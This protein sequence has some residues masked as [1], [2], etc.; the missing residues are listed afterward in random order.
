MAA[1]T[2]VPPRSL[3]PDPET[4]RAWSWGGVVLILAGCLAVEVV[5]GLVTSATAESWYPTLQKPT[6]TPP[7]WVFGPVWTLLFGM[8]AVA[9]SIVWL[10]RDNE[11]V[12]CPLTGFSVQLAANLLWSVLFFGLH[13]PFLA[14]LDL[15][16]LWVAVGVTLAQFFNVSRLAAALMVPYFVW[17]TFAALL[18]GAIVAMAA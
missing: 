10:A 14:F 2:L 17:V 8:M 5:G 6:W 1:C 15:L 3:S 11:E 9:A 4:H 12:C 7:S 13:S 16:F 18:N